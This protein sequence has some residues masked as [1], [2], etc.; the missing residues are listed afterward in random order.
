VI[1]EA[2]QERHAW[3][4]RKSSYS[5][6]QNGCVEVDHKASR[7]GIRDTKDASNTTLAMTN[8]GFAQFLACLRS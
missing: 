3:R 2:G 8:Q 5:Q 1:D 4:G 7:V 6:G